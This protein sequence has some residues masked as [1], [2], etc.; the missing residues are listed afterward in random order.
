MQLNI[1][2]PVLPNIFSG[3][4]RKYVA[5]TN[6]KTGGNAENK[7]FSVVDW[8]LIDILK[9]LDQFGGATKN[10]NDEIEEL[11]LGQNRLEIRGR[12]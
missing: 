11:F 12:L 1:K 8:I 5:K 4:K 7:P 3:N 10:Q 2:I 9:E 6:T